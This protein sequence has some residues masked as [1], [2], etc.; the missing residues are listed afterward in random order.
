MI[1]RLQEFNR[2]GADLVYEPMLLSHTPRPTAGELMFE[3]LRFADACERIAQN[4]IN[5]LEHA[6]RD[7]TVGFDPMAEVLKKLAV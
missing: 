7:R 2:T 4:S 1:A 3:W 5:Q 6:K